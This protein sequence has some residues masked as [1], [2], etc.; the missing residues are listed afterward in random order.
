MKLSLLNL[1][2]RFEILLTYLQSAV[3]AQ[4]LAICVGDAT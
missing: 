4:A 2:G 1:L 3:Q